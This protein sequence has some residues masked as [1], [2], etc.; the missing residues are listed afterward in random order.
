MFLMENTLCMQQRNTLLQ[1]SIIIQL[2]D[3]LT[4]IF[5]IFFNRR[6]IYRSH[7]EHQY[8]ISILILVRNYILSL[9]YSIT[10]LLVIMQRC[11]MQAYPSGNYIPIVI[12]SPN[13]IS[14]PFSQHVLWQCC[15]PLSILSS[16]VEI[17]LFNLVFH[18]G[19]TSVSISTLKPPLGVIGVLPLNPEH[20]LYYPFVYK[21]SSYTVIHQSDNQQR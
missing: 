6:K 19:V 5:A 16:M 1:M 7:R 4:L 15:N 8:S 14:L 13:H 11:H 12:S 3:I 20:L 21:T 18:D 9:L 2:T 10:L 17:L